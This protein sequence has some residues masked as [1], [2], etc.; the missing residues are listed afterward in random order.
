MQISHFLVKFMIKLATELNGASNLALLFFTWDVFAYS[1]M[2]VHDIGFENRF[3]TTKLVE[4]NV[5]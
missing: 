2:L 3:L 5:K 1:F 4:F